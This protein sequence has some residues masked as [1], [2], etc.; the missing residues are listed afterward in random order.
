MKEFFDFMVKN[1][2]TKK[3]KVIDLKKELTKN[4]D[5]LKGQKSIKPLFQRFPVKKTPEEAVKVTDE[6]LQQ[7]AIEKQNLGKKFSKIVEG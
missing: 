3:E 5:I 4:P 1:L 6:S 7:E 2:S